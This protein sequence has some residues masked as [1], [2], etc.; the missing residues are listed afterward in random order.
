MFREINFRITDAGKPATLKNRQT[1]GG[2]KK[3][4][5]IS[6]PPGEQLV[7]KSTEASEANGKGLTG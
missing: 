7:E 3:W 2:E 1:K 6:D 4:E 5:N